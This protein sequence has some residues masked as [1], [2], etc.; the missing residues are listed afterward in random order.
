MEPSRDTIATVEEPTVSSKVVRGKPVSQ[1]RQLR[2]TPSEMIWAWGALPAFVLSA[3][4]LV[5]FYST[6]SFWAT[7]FYILLGLVSIVG[8]AI[9][10]YE[11]SIRQIDSECP[12]C[13]VRVWFAL[14]RRNVDKETPI[15]RC[16]RCLAYV[17]Q[18]DGEIQE[19]PIETV[20][21]RPGFGI[22]Y[23]QYEDRFR[24][25]GGVKFIMPPFCAIC[26][27][28]DVHEQREIEVIYVATSSGDS[29]F[30]REANYELRGSYSPGTA[31]APDGL[32]ASD[33][34]DVRV[35]V[36]ELHGKSKAYRPFPLSSDDWG[37]LQFASYR[38]YK[39]FCVAN[40]ITPS[41]TEP[42]P[43][44]NVRPP[45]GVPRRGVNRNT[46]TRS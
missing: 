15:A 20:S 35:P 25:Q 38:F 36:C 22:H 9:L 43:A 42:I 28:H 33:L 23:T 1:W 17:A 7:A 30:W 6:L 16:G 34:R 37:T 26:G 5:F 39:A 18:R 8:L 21:E 45:D 31:S 40:H 19:V 13:G 3:V 29:V 10:S 24:R 27:S 11:R 41:G 46:R 4:K 44:A 14:P 2:K 32:T 12:A